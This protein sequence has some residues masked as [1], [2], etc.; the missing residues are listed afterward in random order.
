[1]P[2]CPQSQ[3]EG[4]EDAGTGPQLPLYFWLLAALFIKYEYI[5][6]LWHIY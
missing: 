4:E 6:T 1:M 5:I 3:E 2:T